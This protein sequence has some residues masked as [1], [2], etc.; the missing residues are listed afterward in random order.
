M[1]PL[2]RIAQFAGVTLNGH[3]PIVTALS[4]LQF[5]RLFHDLGYRVGAEIGVW[6]G[7]FAEA[8]CRGIPD[9]QL[10][11]VDPWLPYEHY[12]EKKNR[13]DRLTEAYDEARRRL[14]GFTCHLDRRMSAEAAVDVPDGSLDFVYID[15]NHGEAFVRQD[16]ECWSPKVRRGG[17]VA[18]HDYG[19]KDRHAVIEV[20]AAV[21]AFTAD[22]QIAPWFVASGDKSHSFFWVV[23]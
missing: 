16:L 7:E 23:S 9:L 10:R 1:T 18:G 5:P 21:D 13:G 19:T 4:R 2:D 14:H 15:A 22:H 6:R 12:R 11:C 8:L 3:A 17:I 20:Q